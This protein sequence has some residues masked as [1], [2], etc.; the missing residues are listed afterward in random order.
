MIGICV[1]ILFLFGCAKQYKYEIIGSVMVND[2][3]R[4][5]VWYTDTI[6]F[7]SDTAYYVNSDNSVVEIISPYEI[8]QLKTIKWKTIQSLE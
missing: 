5:A 7:K 6:S 1:T 3:L 4:E 2:T 8:Y